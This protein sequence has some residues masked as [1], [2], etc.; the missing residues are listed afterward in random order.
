MCV[1]RPPHGFSGGCGTRVWRPPHTH[2]TVVMLSCVKYNDL[3]LSVRTALLIARNAV[4]DE[5][6]AEATGRVK[7]SI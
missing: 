3:Y 2:L 4:T 7:H 5:K 1:W 6:L